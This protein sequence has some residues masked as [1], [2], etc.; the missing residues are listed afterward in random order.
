MEP[1]GPTLRELFKNDQIARHLLHQLVTGEK[2]LSQVEQIL[3]TIS[4]QAQEELSG[5]AD[6]AKQPEEFR[7]RLS[8][9]LTADPLSLAL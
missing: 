8:A 9:A 5:I 1:Q 4:Q 2:L 7:A 6:G 3:Q